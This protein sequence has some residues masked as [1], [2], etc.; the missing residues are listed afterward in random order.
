M[1]SFFLSLLRWRTLVVIIGLVA[2]SALIWYF[3]PVIHLFGTVPLGDEQ[4]RAWAIVALFGLVLLSAAARYWRARRANALMISK[5]M[6]SE[7]LISLTDTQS[8]EE[9]AILRERFEESLKLLRTTRLG[10]TGSGLMLDLPWYIIIGPPGSGKTTILRNSG[11]DFPLAERVGGDVLAGMGGTRNCDWWFTNEAVILDTA[12]RYTTQDSNAVIDRA[13][14]RGFLDLLKEFR[15][16]RPLN[17]V[18]LT[19]SLADVLT[20]NADERTEQIDIFRRRL[21]ELMRAFGLR[22]PVYLL[23]TKCDLLPGFTEFFNSLSD[24]EREQVWGM[25]FT[26]DQADTALAAGYEEGFT[27][28]VQRIV[29]RMPTLLHEERDS[30]RRRLIYA[31]PQ[32]FGAVR[33]LVG[34]FV[35]EVFRVNRYEMAPMLRGVFFTSGTQEGTPID[36][37]MGSFS[38]AFGLPATPVVRA[39]VKAKTFFVRQL[40]LDVVFAESGLAGTNKK[41]ERRLAL[42]HTGGYALALV[43]MGLLSLAW[44]SAYTRSSADA[45]SFG[46]QAAELQAVRIATPARDLPSTVA[47]LQRA[48]TLS[49]YYDDSGFLNGWVTRI[50][51]ASQGAL[52]PRGRAVYDRLLTGELLPIMLG[53]IRQE[54]VNA[55]VGTATNSQVHD[56]LA[57]YLMQG[58]NAHFDR[59]ALGAWMRADAE[60][61]FPLDANRRAALAAQ[62][63]ALL[64]RLP[65]SQSLDANVIAVARQRLVRVPQATAVYAAL[66][67]QADRNTAIPAFSFAQALG[68]AGDTAF[69]LGGGAGIR[70]IVPGFYTRQGFYD[71][72]IIKLPALVREQMQMDWVLGQDNGSPSVLAAQDLVRQVSDLYVHD[73]IAAWQLAISRV[74][75]TRWNSFDELQTVLQTLVGPSRPLSRILGALRDQTNLPRQREAQ[76]AA[77]QPAAAPPAA[78]PPGADP[79]TRLIASGTQ[80]LNN[81]ESAAA[82]LLFPEP[83]PGDQIR[84]PFLPLL[85]LVDGQQPGIARVEEEIAAVYAVIS[86]IAAND[87]PA[88]A[89]LR[90]QSGGQQAQALDAA[91]VLRNDAASRPEPIHTIMLQVANTVTGTISG[92]ARQRVSSLWRND[93]LPACRAV[94]GNRYPFVRDIK[95]EVPLH[96]FT[97][98]FKPGGTMEVFAK[99]FAPPATTRVAAPLP[100]RGAPG[101]PPAALEEIAGAE[102]IRQQFFAAGGGDPLVRFAITPLDLSPRLASATIR[103]DDKSIVY[104]HDPPQSTDFQWPM[105]MEA[106]SVKITLRDFKTEY[107]VVDEKGTWALF[108]MLDNVQL[109]PTARPDTFVLTVAHDDLTAKFQLRASSLANPFSF[110]ALRR[111]RCTDGF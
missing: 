90:Y 57:L 79:G 3:G 56:L 33:N 15:R 61:A 7:G 23:I 96:D 5:L 1:T 12:G 25:S 26:P 50:G 20:R 80:A 101:L 13:A 16:R 77:A 86:Q 42:L 36:R 31:F 44:F 58:D 37:L 108:R 21:Q 49:T 4:A 54:V 88:E 95:D 94:V 45:E 43:V 82:G 104:R 62:Y 87:D 11:L 63:Q 68:G 32:Q 99:R 60:A 91:A 111:F 40:L 35:N 102:L 83:W 18:M 38:R 93:V 85:A 14:W 47:Q 29:D 41:L 51:L 66:R 107:T 72:F 6:D 46:A 81:A 76:P 73:Y 10:G 9:V 24:A 48:R 89:A 71:G 84:Q 27:T 109:Q 59:T 30:P 78:A 8:V 70:T 100:G 98:F 52:A 22:L 74:R 106:S 69:G 110:A 67:Q 75:L 92:A 53:R 105:Q 17:G 2:V 34:S 97:D 64:A 28:L 39:N 103:I 19:I 65:V 55:T